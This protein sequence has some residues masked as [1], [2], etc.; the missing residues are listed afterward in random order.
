MKYTIE[1][2]LKLVREFQHKYA[3]SHVGGSIGLFLH[4]LDMKRPLN[5]SDIDMTLKTLL[6]ETFDIDDSEESSN[7]ED[8][9]VQL[10]VYPNKGGYYIKVDINVNEK[11][12]FDVIEHGGFKYNVSKKDEILEWKRKYADKGVQKHIDDLIA[13]ETGIRPEEKIHDEIDDLPF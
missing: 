13:I 6:P 9:D 7:P 3:L 1:D 4:G 10:R 8:F 2:Y 11:S 5:N 12:S